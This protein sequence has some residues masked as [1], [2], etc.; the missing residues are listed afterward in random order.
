MTDF[1]NDPAREASGAAAAEQNGTPDS[2]S[3]AARDSLIEAIYR[4]ALDPQTYDT[5]MERWDGYV[6]TRVAHEIGGTE[7]TDMTATPEL[8][9]HFALASKL[10]DETMPPPTVDG[11]EPAAPGAGRGAAR[12]LIDE[13]GVIVWYNTAAERQFGLR[14]GATID[15]LGLEEAHRDRLIE[16]AAAL[17]SSHGS[18]PR[19]QIFTTRLSETGRDVHFQA[20]VITETAGTEVILVTRLSASWPAGVATLIR[21][22]FAMTPSEIDICE[23]I[24]DGRT[25]SQIAELRGASVATVRTQIKNIMAKTRTSAQPELV[26]LLHLLIRISED[27]PD[28]SLR[29]AEGPGLRRVELRDGRSM[30]VELHGPE[31]G[32]PVIFFHGMLDGMAALEHCR[33]LLTQYNLRF[34]CPAR[35]WFGAADPDHGPMAGSL[36]RFAQ[37]VCEMLKDRN[38]RSPVLLGHM[39]GAISAH[40][41]AAAANSGDIRGLVSVSG[42][43]PI[44]GAGQFASMTTR[45]R[46]VAY[47]ARYSPR[48]LPFLLRAGIRQMRTGG[49]RKFLMSLYENS[50]DDL[51]VI[52][53]PDVQDMVLNGYR[54]TVAQGHRAFEIDSRHVVGNWSGHVEAT[55]MPI[56]LIHGESDP[57][58]AL[59]SVEDFA[60]RYHNRTQLTRIDGTGQLI[61]YKSPEVVLSAVRNMLD[62]A[63]A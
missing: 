7:R 54:F 6:T 10:L 35:P 19:P 59:S 34:I 21:E 50:P 57:V 40:A 43:V 63:R 4:I 41:T 56:H 11:Q 49:E 29:V 30:P 44:L 8:D 61:F 36:D 2:T 51:P 18:P 53:D 45:Q 25:A 13:H 27:H 1:H 33:D 24:A 60:R 16:M 32:D 26:R 46:V 42:G 31:G 14:R 5:F 28:H 37:D 58:V 55:E 3:T 17:A 52:A 38:L 23:W 22:N 20:R 12:C 15:T 62:L 47:T 9:T 39:A 48:V